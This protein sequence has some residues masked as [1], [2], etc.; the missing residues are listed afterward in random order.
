MRLISILVSKYLGVIYFFV[1]V[2]VDLSIGLWCEVVQK[3]V[4]SLSYLFHNY[5]V[6]LFLKLYFLHK[7]WIFVY[8]SLVD[9]IKS[10]VC[11]YK[12]IDNLLVLFLL[13]CFEVTICHTKVAK[14]YFIFYSYYFH[15]KKSEI[16]SGGFNNHNVKGSFLESQSLSAF[17]SLSLNFNTKLVATNL[18]FI[19]H[20]FVT[21]KKFNNQTFW[22]ALF[23]STTFCF[24]PSKRSSD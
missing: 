4:Y 20:Q 6:F 17:E 14:M 23:Q 5:L 11:S 13:I 2:E 10:F 21:K 8:S 18:I 7:I 16:F 22:C 12:E 1:Y 15:F 24:P 19:L 3:F 9:F